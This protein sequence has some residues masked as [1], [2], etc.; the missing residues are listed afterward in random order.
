ME[1]LKE[2]TGKVENVLNCTVEN[3]LNCTV[4]Y[5]WYVAEYFGKTTQNP[6]MTGSN[7][8][9][10]LW[11]WIVMLPFIGP[12]LYHNLGWEVA[13]VAG[14]CFCF[15]QACFAEYDTSISEEKCSI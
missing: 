2:I 3:V 14:I 6:K 7:L 10:I 1:R 4:D 11:I 13:V 8:F 5:V 12:L 15:Y 9:F